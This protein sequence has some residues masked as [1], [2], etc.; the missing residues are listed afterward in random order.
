MG[1][2]DVGFPKHFDFERGGDCHCRHASRRRAC[3]HPAKGRA[4]PN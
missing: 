4:N 2:G 1:G 3:K